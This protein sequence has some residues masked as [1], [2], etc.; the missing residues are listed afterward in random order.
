V[1]QVIV[2]SRLA[3]GTGGAAVW[4]HSKIAAWLGGRGTLAGGAIVQSSIRQVTVKMKSRSRRF[5]EGFRRGAKIG[6]VCGVVIWLLVNAVLA[7]LLLVV[8]KLRE[9]ALADYAEMSLLEALGNFIAPILLM[10]VYGA[11]PGAAI[12][13]IANLIRSGREEPVDLN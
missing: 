10:V 8:P 5:W 4:G 3:P 13:G 9:R 11:I 12:M 7:V 1:W 6:A 2:R